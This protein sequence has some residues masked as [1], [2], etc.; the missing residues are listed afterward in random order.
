MNI[1]ELTWNW[2]NYRYL[3]EFGVYS[4]IWMHQ[5]AGGVW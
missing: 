3:V 5:L 2:V 1:E 4:S